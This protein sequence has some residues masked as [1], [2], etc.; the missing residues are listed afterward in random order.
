MRKAIITILQFF[1]FLIVFGAFSLFPP[2]HI[3][4]VHVFSLLSLATLAGRHGWQVTNAQTT[5]DGNLIAAFERL[6]AP[7]GGAGIDQIPA[8]TLARLQSMAESCRNRLQSLIQDR[9]VIV[10][11]A[12]SAGVNVVKMM[13]REPDLWTDGN[14]NK[15]GKG[16]VGLQ[17][18]VVSPERALA[19]A[20][21]DATGNFLLIVASTFVSEILPRLR[22]LGWRREVFDMMGNRL[23]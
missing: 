9:R 5:E 14:S 16:F 15:V 8:S 18:R 12:G 6:A 1:L 21:A 11:G 2:F 19:D 3:E 13:G 7:R 4:H 23:P 22:E 10:W 17:S 20:S